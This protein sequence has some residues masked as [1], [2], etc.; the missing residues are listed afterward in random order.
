MARGG[1]RYGLV[2]AALALLLAAPARADDHVVATVAKPTTIDAYGGRAVW[3]AWDESAHAYRLTEYTADHGV[4]TLPL[5]P[6]AAPFDVDLGPDARGG[7]LAV[8]SRCAK[9]PVSTWSLDGRHGCDLFAYGFGPRGEFRVPN[10]NSSADEY[11]PTVWRSRIAFTRTYRPKQHRSRRFLYW[12]GFNGTAASHRL[13]RGPTDR[14]AV[15]ER[16]DLRSRR[17]AFDWAYEYGSE[18]RLDT[19]TG[20]EH[21]LVRLPGSGA[22][23]EDLFVQGPTVVGDDVFWGLA[24]GGDV[25]VYSEVRRHDLGSGRD[26]RATMT[27]RTADDRPKATTGFAQDGGVSWYVRDAGSGSYEIHRADG[28]AYEP[29]PPPVIR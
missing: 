9:T 10:A 24:V 20:H 21:R 11:W 29:A 13:D 7:T 19:T 22:A 25:P 17:V 6:R 28:L 4:R 15:P 23:V 27:I 18:L 2:A 3:S 12:R 8:Y 1:I 16:L 14:A 5:R 26:T